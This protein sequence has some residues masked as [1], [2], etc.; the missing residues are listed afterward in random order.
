MIAMFTVT[1]ASFLAGAA[2]PANAPRLPEI[3]FEKY[4]LPN[5]LQVILHEDHSTPIV[6]VNVWYHVGSKNERPGRT[7]F[8]HL[9]EHM[10]FQGSQHYDKDYFGPLQQAGGQLNGSTNMDRTNYWETVPSNYLE[11]ALWME[12][13]RMG[14][15]VPAMSQEKLDNQRDVV[16]NERRQS[17]ENRPYGLVYEVLL[18]GSY[19]PDH[20]YSW[21][22]IGSMADLAAASREDVADFFRRYYHP[23][24]ASLCLAGDFDPAT[25]RRLI[26]KYF[27]PIPAGPKV[28]KVAPPAVP[29]LPADLRVRMTDRVGLARMYLSWHTV[30]LYATDDA[31]LDVLGDVLAGGKTSRLYR[32]LVRD[33]QIAQDVVAAQN[34]R[35]LAGSFMVVVT[36]RPGQT[37]AELEAAVL[38]EIAKLQNEPP[39]AEEVARAVA[40][41]ESAAIQQLESVGGFGG[42]ADQLNLY[43]VYTGDP[44]FLQQDFDRYL[45]VDPAA[46]QRVAQQY[47]SAK[48]MILEIAPGAETTIT[49]DPREPASKAREELAKGYRETPLPAAPAIAE[50]EDRKQLPRGAAPPKFELPP[51]HR[52]T[53]S[54]GMQVLVV[55]NHELPSL[56]LNV[57]FPVGTS[58]DKPDK[59][60]LVDLL[61]A[62]WNEGT[63]T[64]SSEQIAEALANIGARLSVSADWDT[65]GA[66]LY[67]LKRTLPQ[68]LEVFA[69]VLQNPAFPADELER[70]RNIAI[71]RLLQVRNEPNALASLATGAKL[72]GPEH[73]YGRPE[74][75]S[76]GALK[77]IG[78]D[79]LEAFYRA[80]VRPDGASLIAVGDIT[81][82]EIARELERALGGWKAAG[83]PPVPAFPPLPTP[84]PTRLTL[85]DKPGA[86]QSVISVCLIGTERKSPDYFAL[87]VMNTI[88]GGQFSSRLN[89]NLRE[90]KGY[91]YGARTAFEWRVHQ[92]GPFVARAAV[93]TAVTAPALAEFL[94]EFAGIRGQR[95]VTQDELEFNKNYLTRGYPARFETPSDM[96]GQ[97]EAIIQFQ[98]PDDYFNSVIPGITAVTGDEVVRVANK[99]LDVGRLAIII[100]GDRSQIEA[101]LRKLPVGENLEVVQFDDEFRLVP[102][103]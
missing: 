81:A 51:I 66:Q 75:S 98:L 36:A 22:T 15:L 26:E 12:S 32:R 21:P 9:F 65:S 78:R 1:C 84:Q 50:D 10:M 86:A 45:K 3:A 96:G 68:A 24:N 34:S 19:P 74:Y 37:L 39:S 23:A 13:D 57:V 88:F 56:S 93:Q 80:H 101:D 72:Y 40:R 41:H 89:M 61:A 42:R 47:L 16:R 77:S 63:Q 95:P 17:Y 76:E 69:D 14:F 44:G 54:N 100:V 90:D 8:A 62:V 55:E 18:A 58:S 87:S 92:P 102:V 28:D 83:A 5:G 11:T 20:P 31:E 38:D 30:P 29:P 49:P 85:V 67:T 60:G 70:Q 2:E 91:T 25:A 6:A 35:E 97:L 94:K 4:Q 82:D 27:G 73:P 48:K 99:Y 64:R 53:L 52:R 33:K 7:G 103:K 46:V 43:N 59:T 79:D 71:G